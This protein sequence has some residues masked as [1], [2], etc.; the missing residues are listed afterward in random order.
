L[1]IE[2][3]GRTFDLGFLDDPDTVTLTGLEAMTLQRV[4]GR[5]LADVGRLFADGLERREFSGDL[6]PSMLF[7]FWLANRH[8]P[9]GDRRT[10]FE[11]FAD[12]LELGR[13]RI[14]PDEPAPAGPAAPAAPAPAALSLRVEG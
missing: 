5:S 3:S 7:V 6:L 9:D 11:T 14:V 4:L 8:G 13:I 12:S 1:R 10:D 2:M